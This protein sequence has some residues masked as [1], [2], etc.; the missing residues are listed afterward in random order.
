LIYRRRPPHRCSSASLR[1]VCAPYMM[2]HVSP[3]PRPSS[4]RTTCGTCAC[5]AHAAHHAAL[6]IKSLRAA[7]RSSL[8]QR[9]S[10]SRSN[11]TDVWL[12]ER[13]PALVLHAPRVARCH[14]AQAIKALSRQ[15]P[16]QSGPPPRPRRWAPPAP[17]APGLG[18]LARPSRRIWS[19]P[20]PGRGRARA[21]WSGRPS[22]G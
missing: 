9:T 22:S 7:L 18:A 19:R 4:A 13:S 2:R 1:Q 20:S 14:T 21:R 3:A 11:S 17:P 10:V 15:N 5:A 8:S 12:C 6:L 16:P